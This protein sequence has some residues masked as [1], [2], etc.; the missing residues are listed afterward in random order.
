MPF[1][2][3]E[4]GSV[5][6]VSFVPWKAYWPIDCK[7]LPKVG[8]LACV[9]FPLLTVANLPSPLKALLP[10]DRTPLL[11]KFTVVNSVSPEAILLGI[12]VKLVAALKFKVV[13]LVILLKAPLPIEVTESGSVIESNFVFLK[14]SLP[15][16]CKRLPKVGLLSTFAVFAV[17]TVP[18]WVAPLKALL[19][20]LLTLAGNVMLVKLVLPSKAEVPIVVRFVLL[21]KFKL[22]MPVPLI[23]RA[24]NEVT[25]FGKFK[26]VKLEHPLKALAWMVVNCV[27]GKLT[28]DRFVHP[29]NALLPIVLILLGN[30]TVC[31]LVLLSTPCDS[32]CNWVACCML[33]VVKP[34]ILLNAPLAKFLIPEPRV[35]LVRLVHPLKALAWIVSRL[36]LSLKL[37]LFNRVQFWKA[38]W[39]MVLILLGSFTVCILALPL[40]KPLLKVVKL[41]TLEKSRVLISVLSIKPLPILLKALLKVIEFKRVL[42]LKAL[43]PIVVVPFGSSTEDK[44]EL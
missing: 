13:K 19:S 21:C 26:V 6:E 38:F 17:L 8:L 28:V 25:L 27:P 41:L 42:F 20:I 31:K 30:V 10:I 24:P 36:G 29:L 5:I 40:T 18:N 33:I 4:A 32:V 14:A 1:E 11:G 2:L 44:P 22:L 43:L 37:T 15:I 16:D 7:L 9:V 34:L 23:N 3:I 39:P 35:M 12:V